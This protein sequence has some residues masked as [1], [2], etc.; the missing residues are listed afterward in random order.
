LL[1]LLREL[2]EAEGKPVTADRNGPCG[3]PFARWRERADE[4]R[5]LGDAQPGSRRR[6]FNRAKDRLR[7]GRRIDFN[8]DLAWPLS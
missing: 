7:E 3:V 4:V 2:V 1:K 6:T 8:D 5:L